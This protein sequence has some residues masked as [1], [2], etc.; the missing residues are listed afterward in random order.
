MP[1]GADSTHDIVRALCVTAYTLGRGCPAVPASR[2][3]CGRQL[4]GEL[5]TPGRG[6]GRR[7]AVVAETA[8]RHGLA[9]AHR[10]SHSRHALARRDAAAGERAGHC[11]SPAMVRSEDPSLCPVSEA[12]PKVRPRWNL[13]GVSGRCCGFHPGFTLGVGRRD[14]PV[15]TDGFPQSGLPVRGLSVWSSRGFLDEHHHAY[16]GPGLW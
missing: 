10:L 3:G 14:V 4:T 16:T 15:P 7:R 1:C 13:H 6:G 11:S 12:R 2:N 5:M 8:R 9:P